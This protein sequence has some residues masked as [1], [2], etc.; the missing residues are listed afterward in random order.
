MPL[1]YVESSSGSPQCRK[2]TGGQRI[3]GEIRVDKLHAGTSVFL[4][5]LGDYA[6]NNVG[7]DIVDAAEVDS[8]HPVPITARCIQKFGDPQPTKQLRKIG[9][10]IL[11][12]T[13]L[14][15]NA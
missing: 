7:A 11:R 2:R 1:R 15:S 9:A 6:G 14:R 8:P 3:F 10:H 13:E 4:A 12:G 5:I